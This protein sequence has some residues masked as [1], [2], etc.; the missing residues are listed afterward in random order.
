MSKMAQIDKGLPM[1]YYAKH[2]MINGI[3]Y[4]HDQ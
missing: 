3:F 1:F 4:T 2:Q